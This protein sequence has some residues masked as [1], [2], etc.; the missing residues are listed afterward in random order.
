MRTLHVPFSYF[1]SPAGG[2]E[3]YVAALA[4]ALQP[5]GMT[6]IVA[7]PG[8]RDETYEW[9]G[10][11]VHRFKT[12]SSA[13]LE[14]LYGDGDVAAAA[15]FGRILDHVRPDLVHFHALTAGASV[16]AMREVKARRIP[17]IFTYHTPTVSCVRGTMMKW[18]EI[19]CDGR[20]SS[21][22]CAACA[23]HGKGIP[24]PVALGLAKLPPSAPYRVGKALKN[25]RVATAMQLPALVR[26]RHQATH[27]VFVLADRLVAVCAWV[28]D[29][30]NSNGVAPSKIEVSRQGLP[31][32]IH[33][34]RSGDA[35]RRP[36]P[37]VY[38]PAFP[39]RLA[40]FGR[41]DPT[42]GVHIVVEALRAQRDLPVV[43]D[44]FGIAQG[45]SGADYRSHLV[46]LTAGDARIRFHAPVESSAVVERMARYDLVL[47]PSLWLETG[48]LVVYEAQAGGVP[49]LGS[50]LGGIAELVIDDQTGRTL[51]AGDIREWAAELGRLVGRP[52]VIER[53]KDAQP[54]PRT[55][56]DAARDMA[57]LYANFTDRNKL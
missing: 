26:R 16:L 40:F 35:S 46:R 54:R 37:N 23:L 20:M 1:P 17:L 7:A 38:S 24:K 42:K 30:L 15:S 50:R 33:T 44:I 29:V 21:R 18:G 11:S 34:L 43:L 22:L 39:L 48:P 5:H 8:D 53:W 9:E 28:Q 14:T 2:T 36:N 57:N 45:S 55:M 25:G 32:N 4:N 49:V 12:S 3:V 10:V 19:P 31:G 27:A 13:E 47:V 41:L 56:A 51:A 52:D 6:S